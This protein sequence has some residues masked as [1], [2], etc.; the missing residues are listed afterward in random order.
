[1]TIS[2]DNHPKS[3]GRGPWWLATIGSSSGITALVLQDHQAAWV[4]LVAFNAWLIHN[5]LITWI[6]VRTPG[7]SRKR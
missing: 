2:G 5:V 6:K 1:M 7:K 3:S 4:I